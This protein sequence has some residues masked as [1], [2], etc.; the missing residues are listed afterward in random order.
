MNTR[1]TQPTLRAFADELA[2]ALEP[3]TGCAWRPADGYTPNHVRL[4]EVGGAH[5]LT[6]RSDADDFARQR[7]VRLTIYGHIP[8]GRGGWRPSGIDSPTITVSAG[9]PIAVLACD[10]A[11]RVWPGYQ[12]AY[13]EAQAKI[14]AHHAAL[15]RQEETVKL[16]QE[17][18]GASRSPHGSDHVHGRGWDAQLSYDGRRLYELKLHRVDIETACEIL[19]IFNTQ[20]ETP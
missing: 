17:V 10:I 13:A 8:F 14:A 6:L 19:R 12:E 2:P 9:R 16:L 11:R 3:E 15:D 7:P 20:E 1:Q 4:L 18:A 5:E